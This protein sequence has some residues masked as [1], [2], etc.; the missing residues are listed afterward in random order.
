[1]ETRNEQPVSVGNWILT[2]LVMM[3]PIVNIIMVFVWAFSGGT[4]VSKSNWAKAILIWMLIGIVIG[5]IGGI[6]AGV[7]GVSMASSMQG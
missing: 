5:V 6:L 3:I 7:L 4:P 2:M 1:M